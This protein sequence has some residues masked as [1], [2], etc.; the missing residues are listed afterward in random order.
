MNDVERYDFSDAEI[1]EMGRDL[2][3]HTMALRAFEAQK[4]SMAKDFGED[5][6][7]EKEACGKL[8][9]LIRNGFEMRPRLAQRTLEFKQGQ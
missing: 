4:K 9:E 8:A 7:S 6:K 5:I 2:A 3:R 1:N